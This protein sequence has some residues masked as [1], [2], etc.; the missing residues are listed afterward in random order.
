MSENG[1][2]SDDGLVSE[3]GLSTNEPLGRRDI[4]K[5]AIPLFIAIALI[6]APLVPWPSKFDAREIQIVSYIKYVVEILLVLAIAGS[7]F[8]DPV[9]GR[10]R[11]WCET[12]AENIAAEKQAALNKAREDVL[13]YAKE[14]KRFSE[15]GAIR[16]FVAKCHK[17]HAISSNSLNN[18]AILFGI[19][20]KF[21]HGGIY[22]VTVLVLVALKFSM[23]AAI[24]HSAS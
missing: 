12:S 5:L 21:V 22:G 16:T 4:A 9:A 8:S 18:Y 20:S 23:D 24:L 10:F 14:P 7:I 1:S 6:A 3:P 2:T 15:K 19:T 11:T 13:A 17:L